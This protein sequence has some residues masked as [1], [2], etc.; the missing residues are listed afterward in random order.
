V[1]PEPDEFA[2]EFIDNLDAG[3]AA[4]KEIAAVL[5]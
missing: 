4:Y 2:L 1:L 3:L 5:A